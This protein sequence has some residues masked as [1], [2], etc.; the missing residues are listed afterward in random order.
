MARRRRTFLLPFSDADIDLVPL[1]DCV[2]LLL[3]F[4]MLCGHLTVTQRAEQI[5]VP[6]ARTAEKIYIDQH[7][8]HEVINFGGERIGDPVRIRFGQSFDSAN[9]SQPEAWRRL[10][11]YL[12]QLYDSSPS[13]HH[14]RTDWPEHKQV[15]IELR[16]DGE[17][18]WHT[19]QTAQQILAD[20]ID[21]ITGLPNQ[22]PHRRPFI[23]LLFST[24]AE[25]G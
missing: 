16:A 22:R 11:L 3:L 18:P 25:D 23:E 2:F 9:L 7:W 10:R 5:T 19:I 17:V 24:R 1:I 6:P 14:Q 12:D 15:I 8:R 21:P 13:V 20:S 4:F